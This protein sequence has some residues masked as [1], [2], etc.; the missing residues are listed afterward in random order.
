MTNSLDNN[1]VLNKDNHEYRLLSEPELTFTSVTTFVDSFFEGFDSV[2]IATN[3]VQ[4]HPRYAGCTVESL[5]AIWD[6]ARDHGTLVHDEIENWIKYDVEPQ[7][8]KAIQGKNWLQNYQMKSDIDI[9]SELIVYSSKLK[10]AGTVDILAQDNNTGQYELIDWKTSKKIE[11]VSY[12]YKMGTHD[13]T[14]NVMDCNF[15]HYALQLSL[16]RYLLEEYYDIRIHNQL[17]GHIQDEGVNAIVAPYMKD[18]IVAMLA[19]RK[20]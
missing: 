15:Y 10:I 9:S 14:E 2:K 18:E 3:L 13:V 4:N 17:I 12:G 8:I 19:T 16:Y 7:T 1:I 11:T 20:D 5:I 6:K